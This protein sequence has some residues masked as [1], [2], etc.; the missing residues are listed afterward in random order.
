MIVDVSPAFAGR[1]QGLSIWSIEEGCYQAN[2]KRQNG[3]WMIGY[4]TTPQAALDDVWNNAALQS[5]KPVAVKRRRT[6][7]LI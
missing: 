2:V 4:G 6:M 7:D 5:T 3:G 1:N